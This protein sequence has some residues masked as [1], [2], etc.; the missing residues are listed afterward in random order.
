MEVARNHLPRRG[1]CAYHII[2]NLNFSRFAMIADVHDNGETV[3]VADNGTVQHHACTTR[4]AFLILRSA[5]RQL[6]HF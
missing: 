6:E 4:A 2:S 5:K 3:H 1:V